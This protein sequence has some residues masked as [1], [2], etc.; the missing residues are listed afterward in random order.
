MDNCQLKPLQK[1]KYNN[2]DND[3]HLKRKR[4]NPPIAKPST[5]ITDLFDDCLENI[6]ER[7][8]LVDL[9]NVAVANEWLRPAACLVYKRK[10]GKKVVCLIAASHN[11]SSAAE[12]IKLDNGSYFVTGLT[13]CLQYLRCFGSSIRSLRIWY[14][15]LPWDGCERIHHYVDQFCAENLIRIGFYCKPAGAFRKFEKPFLKIRSVSL[16]N[17]DFGPQISSVCEWFPNMQIF[18]MENVR[19]DSR[20]INAPF[21]HL[22]CLRI[23]INDG[24]L[25]TGFTK[26]QAARLL[27]FCPQLRIVKICIPGRQG[28]KMPTLLNLLR[29]NRRISIV[30]LIMDKYST[31]AKPSDI[32]R[33][34]VQ[35]PTITNF[36]VKNYKFT[37]DTAIAMIH[38]LNSLRK[39]EF[40]MKNSLEYNH[41][42]PM[43]CDQW[44]IALRIGVRHS[45]FVTLVR[46]N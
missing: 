30:I 40:Q 46:K 44:D 21:H 45:H 24:R 27:H 39:F 32:Q 10:F 26:P 14:R 15:D 11:L 16:I 19:V 42:V 23:D 8:D 43:L 3:V 2:Y 4:L 1:R 18:Q 34:I 37:A 5:K 25:R 29:H 13:V 7:L 36:D 17:G 20:G 35:H 31:A 33:L 38:E 6:F 22:Q 41:F 12:S 9:F 28:M